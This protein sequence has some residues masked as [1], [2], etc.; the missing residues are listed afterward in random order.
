MTGHQSIKEAGDPGHSY[1]ENTRLREFMITVAK[2][3]TDGHKTVK[4]H[5][6]Q[7]MDSVQPES[8]RNVAE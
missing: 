8:G 3:I 6:G 7:Q 1:Q 5:H 2:W 4:T